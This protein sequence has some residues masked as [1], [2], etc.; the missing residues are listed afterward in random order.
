LDAVS[1]F[2]E[3]IKS[4]KYEDLLD[5]EIFDLGKISKLAKGYLNGDEVIGQDRADLKNLISLC[6]VGWY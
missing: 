3:E 1:F 5:P 4:K 2:K 6:N